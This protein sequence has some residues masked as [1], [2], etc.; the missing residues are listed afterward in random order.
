MKRHIDQHRKGLAAMKAVDRVMRAY[1]LRY[2]VAPEH[3]AA[4]RV[5]L[6]KIIERF[7][8]VKLAGDDQSGTREEALP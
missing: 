1:S 8:L 3:E 4:I 6:Q 2:S 7:A 5:E